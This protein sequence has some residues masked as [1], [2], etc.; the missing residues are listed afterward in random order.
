MAKWTR[1]PYCDK[2][3]H[4]ADNCPYLRKTMEAVPQADVEAIMREVA[5]NPLIAE[6]FNRRKAHRHYGTDPEPKRVPRW[7]RRRG[8]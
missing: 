6:E 7:K 3:G 2:R 5:R 1:C 8:E 4:E